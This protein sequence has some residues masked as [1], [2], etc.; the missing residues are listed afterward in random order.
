MKKKILLILVAAVRLLFLNADQAFAKSPEQIFRD[1]TPGI[2]I[3]DGL[4]EQGSKVTLGSGVVISTGEVITN[5]HVI[6][7]AAKIDVRQG[8]Q[9]FRA[10]LQEKN[11][12][13]DLCHLSVPDL[14]S[15]PVTLAK[16]GAM[17]SPGARVY[18]IGAPHGLELSISD[19]LVSAVREIDNYKILQT[20]APISPGSSGGGLFD[21]DGQLVG[22]TTFY[23]KDGQNLNFAVSIDSLYEMVIAS[24][25]HPERTQEKLEGDKRET[26]EATD[27][28]LEKSEARRK[29]ELVRTEMEREA[30]SAYIR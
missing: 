24:A 22:I 10:I 11:A 9:A 17:P 26:V 16:R 27:E 8:S 15:P 1:V 2:V 23:L 3:V 13:R 6:D 21:S 14:L 30:E 19:G 29:F 25:V 18:A 4:D 28:V 5:C 20:T 7:R 12:K